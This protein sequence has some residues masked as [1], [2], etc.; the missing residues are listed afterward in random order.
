MASAIALLRATYYSLRRSPHT[1]PFRYATLRLLRDI[2]TV[3]CYAAHYFLTLMPCT[4]RM[5]WQMYVICG[6]R[7]HYYRHCY[8]SL[9]RYAISDACHISPRYAAAIDYAL[10]FL[11]LIMD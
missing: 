3:I 11:P 8:F 1:P 4:L 5:I 10:F 7:C 6:A 9:L 2:A